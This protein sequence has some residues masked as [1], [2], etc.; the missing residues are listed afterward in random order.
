MLDGVRNPSEAQWLREQFKQFVLVAVDAPWDA[1]WERLRHKPAWRGRP[2][3]EFDRVASRDIDSPVAWGSRVQAC[4]DIADYVVTN[5]ADA[6]L[7]VVERHLLA[8]A[9]RLLALLD[10]SAAA[11][12]LLPRDEEV[13][14]NLAHAGSSRSACLKRQVGAIIVRPRERPARGSLPGKVVGIGYNE[15]PDYMQPCFA[16]FNACYRD[17]W[18]Q[19][20]IADMQLKH[21][22]SCGS[23]IDV[24]VFPPVC[25]NPV[26]ADGADLLDVLFPERAMSHCTALHAEVR[27][28]LAT[29]GADLAGTTIYVT[30]FP[31]FRCAR[32]TS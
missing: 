7:P 26:C 12:E 25:R 30:T 16:E 4:V 10:G 1:R 8:E 5:D 29:A 13:F 24:D 32:S 18:R 28:V 31:C 11:A 3:V 21:C 6:E 19:K 14:M 27:A 20:R 17:I 2:R 9:D 15:N 23:E 22:P